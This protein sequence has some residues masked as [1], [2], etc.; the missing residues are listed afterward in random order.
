MGERIVSSSPRPA[1]PPPAHL[2]APASR[3]RRAPPS[4]L[5]LRSLSEHEQRYVRSLRSLCSAST[6][7]YSASKSGGSDVI[8]FNVCGNVQTACAPQEVDGGMDPAYSRGAAVQVRGGELD[9]PPL[10]YT[11][12]PSSLPAVFRPAVL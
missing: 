7:G 10:R 12:S 2:P 3:L 11:S 1:A 6:M 8:L 9:P 4:S 5:A